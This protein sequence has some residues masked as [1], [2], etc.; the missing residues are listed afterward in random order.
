MKSKKD[1]KEEGKEGGEGREE[2]R[3]QGEGKEIFIYLLK[4]HIIS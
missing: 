4:E 3:D 1:C 2:G